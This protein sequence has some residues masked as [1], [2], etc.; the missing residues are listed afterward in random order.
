MNVNNSATGEPFNSHV[1]EFVNLQ[2]EMENDSDA[3]SAADHIHVTIC[4]GKAHSGESS[5]S[6]DQATGW[7]L[8][9]GQNSSMSEGLMAYVLGQVVQ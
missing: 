7:R 3:V 6:F 2:R 1:T 8:V 5:I 9:V 4:A